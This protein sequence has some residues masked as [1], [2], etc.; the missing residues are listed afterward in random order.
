MNEPTTQELEELEPVI[1]ADPRLRRLVDYLF[2]CCNS[3]LK[4]ME[5]YQGQ[6]DK[7][8]AEKIEAADRAKSLKGVSDM[9][10]KTELEYFLL[11]EKWKELD[12][13]YNGP[14]PANDLEGT[15]L[16]QLKER[17]TTQPRLVQIL[18]HPDSTIRD[19]LTRL[20]RSKRIKNKRGAGYYI[21]G[22]TPDVI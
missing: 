11:H 18:R 4:A 3:Y 12:A 17:A 8:L 1:N 13:A 6:I 16:D 2:N 22:V 10:V 21:P 20:K 7:L 5:T 9:L 15:I 19:A 14:P